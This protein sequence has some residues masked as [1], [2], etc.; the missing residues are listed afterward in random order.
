MKILVDLN[1]LVGKTIKKAIRIDSDESIAITFTDETYGV[2]SAKMCGDCYD[3]E[4]ENSVDDNT[5]RE[6]G[7]ITEEEYKAIQDKRREKNKEETKIY[8]LNQLARLREKY[9]I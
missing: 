6:I 9:S 8:E 1:E 3:L 5:K 4:L 7:I 2:I